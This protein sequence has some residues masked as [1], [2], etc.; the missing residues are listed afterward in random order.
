MW[1]SHVE[2]RKV[3]EE[4]VLRII[5]NRWR[6]FA[7]A[8]IDRRQRYSIASSHFVNTRCLAII[9]GWRRAIQQQQ[10][11]NYK[12]FLM[13]AD[14]KIT[15]QRPRS[16][17]TVRTSLQSRYAKLHPSPLSFDQYKSNALR[18]NLYQLNDCS[19]TIDFV[20]RRRREAKKRYSLPHYNR[21]NSTSRHY[22]YARPLPKHTHVPNWIK[23]ELSKRNQF[24]SNGYLK[25]KRRYDS[26]GH[27]NFSY[28]NMPSTKTYDMSENMG[29]NRKALQFCQ[30]ITQGA[31]AKSC[32]RPNNFE[33]K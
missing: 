31:E 1:A 2:E 4:V 9:S 12:K 3:R 13:K 27:Y 28:N 26:V 5:L 16:R 17:H 24:H 23:Q 19:G 8:I 10:D 15:R 25:F 33:F 29:K 30:H 20:R 21:T 6:D 11:I 32:S 18:Q 14:R 7:D 22:E